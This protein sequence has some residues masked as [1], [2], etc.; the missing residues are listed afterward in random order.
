MS[1]ELQK[2]S[3]GRSLANDLVASLIAGIAESRASTPIVG[4]KPLLRLLKTGK[5]VF[6]QSDDPVQEGSSWAINPLSIQHGYVCWSNYPGAQKNEM[7]GEIMAPIHERKPEKPAAV[8][9]FEYK[10]ERIFELRCVD[11]EDE[12]VEV[13]YK[14]ASLGAMR[15][16]DGLF[17][18]IRAQLLQDATYPVAVVQLWSKDYQHSK[19]G[20]TFNPVFDIVGWATMT[21]EISNEPVAQNEPTQPTPDPQPAP[22]PAPTPNP[23]PSPEPQHPTPSQPSQP[24]AQ[25]A[26]TKPPLQSDRPGAAPRRQRPVERA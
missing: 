8:N 1:N 7:L 5:W 3:G 9:G 22:T 6:G 17:A 12:G 26:P 10:E 2:N 13:L 21:G 4:G 15:A 19:Y 24:T 23:S 18:Q 11:G 14:G 25:A 20:Q 16:V